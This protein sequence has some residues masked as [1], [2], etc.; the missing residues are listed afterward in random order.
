MPSSPDAGVTAV[1]PDLGTLVQPM[2]LEEFGPADATAA[3]PT[4]PAGQTAPAAQAAHLPAALDELAPRRT[5]RRSSQ[6]LF[7]VAS[8]RSTADEASTP[9]RT[10][11][12]AAGYAA[13]WANGMRAAKEAMAADS[14]AARAAFVQVQQQVVQ[15]RNSA[16]AALDAA[17]ARLERS[18][19]PHADELTDQVLTAAFALAEALVG[20]DLRTDPD[21]APHVLAHVL[22]LAPDHEEVTV[23]LSPVDHA[24]LT[25]DGATP[26]TSRPV[27]LV[28]DATLAPGDAIAVSGAT[29]IDAR[30][31]AGLAR[32]RA[33]LNLSDPSTPTGGAR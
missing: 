16:F 32:V 15:R 10:A 11:A 23:R 25:A 20:H 18:A 22:A 8:Q 2:L 27:R 17:A 6:Q 1:L 21:R 33:A 7:E 13:G 24:T 31:A 19:A 28:A 29:H 30:I 5:P 12:Q 3:R 4:A 26:A 9:E 14:A